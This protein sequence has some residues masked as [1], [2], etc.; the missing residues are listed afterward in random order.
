MSFRLMHCLAP[1]LCLL[2][3][4]AFGCREH[5]E[6]ALKGGTAGT[7]QL[8]GRPIADIQINA[9]VVNGETFR[10]VGF[11]VS[12]ATGDFTLIDDHG[13]TAAILPAGQYKLTLESVAADPIPIP[14]ELSSVRTTPLLK[15][16][17]SSDDEL[18][19]EIK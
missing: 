8:R 3:F 5:P 4:L 7:I 10:R 2:T 14:P 6:S 19:I 17:S 13:Q 15:E 12:D 1:T 16:L 18:A 9:F 11:G